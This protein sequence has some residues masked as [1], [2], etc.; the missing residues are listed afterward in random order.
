MKIIKVGTF[1][2]G[3]EIES[4]ESGTGAI[5]AAVGSR[6]MLPAEDTVAVVQ[7]L[8]TVTAAALAHP[9]RVAGIPVHEAI[10]G[11][12]PEPGDLQKHSHDHLVALSMLHMR[13]PSS[14]ANRAVVNDEYTLAT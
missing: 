10:L 11:P 4:T 12:V 14:L 7:H 8:A 3:A 5:G 13:M 2:T 9:V 6:D 1:G